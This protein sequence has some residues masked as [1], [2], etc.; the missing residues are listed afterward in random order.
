MASA[1]VAEAGLSFLGL[2][3]QPPR[4][5]WGSMLAE[6]RSFVLV[7][8]HLVLAPG[9]AITLVVLALNFLGEDLRDHLDVRR[10]PRPVHRYR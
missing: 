2:G 5:S 9:A 10:R 8:P 7:A 3:V 1:I 4:P 6:A